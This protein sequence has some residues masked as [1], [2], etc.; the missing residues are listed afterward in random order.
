MP[1]RP[2]ASASHERQPVAAAPVAAEFPAEFGGA[3]LPSLFAALERLIDRQTT[4]QS[5][6]VR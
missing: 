6:G 3:V 2:Y 5:G 1:T 4:G